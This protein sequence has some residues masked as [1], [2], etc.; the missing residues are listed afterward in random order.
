MGATNMDGSWFWQ[1]PMDAQLDWDLDN[2]EA[3]LT[4]WVLCHE[5]VQVICNAHF[6]LGFAAVLC[7]LP[8]GFAALLCTFLLGL[9]HCC[10]VVSFLFGLLHCYTLSFWV[11]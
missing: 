6:P 11:C 1:H 10:P 8:F 4:P 9:L 2:E 5:E 3:I 7:S